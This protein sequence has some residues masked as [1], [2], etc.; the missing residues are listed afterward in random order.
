MKK[1][2]LLISVL[3][4]AVN[5]IAK[6]P[7]IGVSGYSDGSKQI[8]NCTYVNAVRLAGGVPVVI[9]VTTDDA[10]IASIVEAIDGLIMTGGEDFDPLKW[11]N[12]EPLRANGTI[13]PQRDEFDVK[14]VRAAVAKGIPV[15][16]IC[17]GHQLLSI[18][19]GGSLYQDIPSQ[20]KNSYIKHYQGGTPG[21]YGT[22]T[23]NI[24]KG[25]LLE[26]QTN[27]QD[28]AVNS[29]HHQ[30]VKDVPVGF[31]VTA[32]SADGV[33]EAMERIGKLNGYKDGGAV[34]MGVQFHPEIFTSAGYD[35]FLG[36]F[37]YLVKESGK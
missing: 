21:S 29:F 10:Q 24:D 34:I 4:L 27:T 31:K 37:Q 6:T 33:I 17:R 12:E 1:T 15:L 28:V 30:A 16:G 3:L 5:L 36:I 9:P 11:Y 8:A 20:I 13:A 22:H 18:A 26:Q 25:S 7:I 23:I 14:L 19:F 32:K 35:T 2:T